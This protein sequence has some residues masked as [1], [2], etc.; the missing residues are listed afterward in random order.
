MIA[1]SMNS[2]GDIFSSFMGGFGGGR[3]SRTNQG[4]TKGADLRANL[5][6]S[7][8]DAYLG[9][10]KEILIYRDE[11]CSTCHGNGAGDGRGGAAC[12]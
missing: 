6:I 11:E 1:D 2:L 9:V 4:P 12:P 8:E 10:E 5:D 7:F 3:S